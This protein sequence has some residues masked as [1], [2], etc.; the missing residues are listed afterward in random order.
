MPMKRR[1]KW[2]PMK[3]DKCGKVVQR[4]PNARVHYANYKRCG[5]LIRVEEKQ[6]Q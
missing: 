1:M 2:I 5:N 6:Q 3:C 4:Y